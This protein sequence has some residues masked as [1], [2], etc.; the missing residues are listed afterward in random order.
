LIISS[1]DS[2]ALPVI[3]WPEHCREQ[4]CEVL[5][6]LLPRSK[7]TLDV[8]P[9]G[10]FHFDAGSGVAALLA[11]FMT[12]LAKLVSEIPEERA[13]QLSVAA[14]ALVLACTASPS[15]SA[16][17][18]QPALSSVS[19]TLVERARV[20]A[21]RNMSSPDFGPAQL[22]KLL[23]VSRSKLYRLLD[24]DGGAARFINRERLTEALRI[25]ATRGDTVSVHSVATQV[26]FVDHST[27]SRAFR[28]AFGCSPSE[29]R[30]QAL[31]AQAALGQRPD[32]NLG[33]RGPA[34]ALDAL[35][36]PALRGDAERG[37]V[38]DLLQ[39]ASVEN[40]MA[41]TDFGILS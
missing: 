34:P 4:D 2:D 41:G 26:G 20:I 21:R 22:A 35:H 29:A 18:L 10:I 23:A 6:L 9:I 11:D 15:D 19:A 30:E 5:S 28:R 39:V 16:A 37:L 8:M 12:Q 33:V 36:R 31:T 24:G 32:E 14:L 3:S 17:P 1:Y 25:L 40:G 38:I 27:F 13:G 7:A